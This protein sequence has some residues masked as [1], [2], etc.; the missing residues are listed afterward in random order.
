MKQSG[1]ISHGAC[2]NWYQ[3]LIPG[4]PV[5]CAFPLV[6]LWP[7]TRV[8][9]AVSQNS[10]T[11][12]SQAQ[13]AVYLGSLAKSF[14]EQIYLF[15]LT[16]CL[17]HRLFISS[18]CNYSIFEPNFVTENLPKAFTVSPNPFI[19]RF[20]GVS[21][22]KTLFLEIAANHILFPIAPWCYGSSLSVSKKKRCKATKLQTSDLKA[23]KAQFTLPCSTGGIP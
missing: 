6:L 14:P 2:V 23:L 4:E 22:I 21:V 20:S 1:N 12:F 8:T 19:E 5:L 18:S 13:F 7:L 3:T 17:C 9:F 10:F 11:S 15:Y 16:E